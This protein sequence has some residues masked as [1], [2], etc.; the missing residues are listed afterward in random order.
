MFPIVKFS[1][2][3]V[4]KKYSYFRFVLTS[5][6][7]RYSLA[8]AIQIIKNI[9]SGPKTL[10]TP[11][12]KWLSRSTQ[13]SLRRYNYLS[14]VFAAKTSMAYAQTASREGLF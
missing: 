14:I 4:N 9:C 3:F 1:H 6:V 10:A 5:P 2:V 12:Y 11:L 7:Y 13:N 8:G